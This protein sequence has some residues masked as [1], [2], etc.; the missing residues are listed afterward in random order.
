LFVTIFCYPLP[1]LAA[2]VSTAAPPLAAPPY[3][4][5]SLLLPLLTAAPPYCCPSL[6]LPL[7][8]AAPPCCCPSL[9]LLTYYFCLLPAAIPSYLLLS[10]PTCC[11]SR[12]PTPTCPTWKSFHTYLEELPDLAGLLCYFRTELDFHPMDVHPFSQISWTQFQ[13]KLDKHP[14]SGWTS[15]LSRTSIHWIEIRFYSEV[16]GQSGS[17]WKFVHVF[18]YSVWYINHGLVRDQ[19]TD[20]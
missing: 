17:I 15:G 5:P 14:I 7:P 12:W 16:T 19:E 18:F 8:T 1:S 9:L 2:I 20:V 6:L 3:W 11:C 13:T 4:R 10:P